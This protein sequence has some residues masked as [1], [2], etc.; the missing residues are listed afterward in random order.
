MTVEAMEAAVAVATMIGIKY[1]AAGFTFSAWTFSN[2][3]TAV[4]SDVRIST[5]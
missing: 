4:D 1:A 2:L 3:M 5:Q